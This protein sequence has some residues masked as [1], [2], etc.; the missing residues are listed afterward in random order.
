VDKTSKKLVPGPGNYDINVDRGRKGFAFGSSKR[1]GLDNQFSKK[2]PGPGAYCTV[3]SLTNLST[4][5]KYGYFF[6]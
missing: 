5:P 4:G 3:N 2:V 1:G 6:L